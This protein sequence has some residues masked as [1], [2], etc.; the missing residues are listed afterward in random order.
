MRARWFNKTRQRFGRTQCAPQ[1]RESPKGD[2]SL[3]HPLRQPIKMGPTGALF[4]W[5]DGGAGREPTGSTKR[6]S[7]LDAR[8]APRR[9]EDRREPIRINLVGRAIQTNRA[10][11][12]GSICL[13]WCVAPRSSLVRQIARL[14]FTLAAGSS[15]GT[16]HLVAPRNFLKTIREN[17]GCCTSKPR[18][19]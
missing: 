3:S 6:A 13:N 4:Y 16:L 11:S 10:P 8:R 5:P 18:R 12:R 7:V 19:H 14:P 17:A 2:S 1:G 9:G 15:P